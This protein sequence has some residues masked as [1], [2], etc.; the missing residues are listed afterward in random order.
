MMKKKIREQRNTRLPTLLEA[1]PLSGA[2]LRSVL[3]SWPG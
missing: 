3:G 2:L 1:N